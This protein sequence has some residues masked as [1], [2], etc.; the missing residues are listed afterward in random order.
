MTTLEKELETFNKNLST[1]MT[2]EGRYVL[3]HKNDVVSIYDT[4]QDA[5]SAGYEKFK[6]EPFLVKKISGL[7]SVLSFT[8]PLFQ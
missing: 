5:L 4:Y 8:R 6:L 3:I 7:E 1:L 2:D